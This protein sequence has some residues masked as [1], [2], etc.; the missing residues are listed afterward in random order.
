MRMQKEGDVLTVQCLRREEVR[1][2]AGGGRKSETKFIVLFVELRLEECPNET[3]QACASIS[4]PKLCN[5]HLPY[6]VNF[7]KN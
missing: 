3:L 1:R 2:Q 7:V 5:F 6:L 4:V